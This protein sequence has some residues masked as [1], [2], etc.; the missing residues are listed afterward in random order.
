MDNPVRDITLHGDVAALH[1]SG[2]I[3]LRTAPSLRETILH[4]LGRDYRKL[5]VNL[6]DVSFM[7]S[8]GLSVLLGALRHLHT[9]GG[10]LLLAECSADIN[11]LLH[12][13]A[14]HDLLPAYSTES[15]AVAALHPTDLRPPA[16]AAP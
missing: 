11:D 15:E 5:V 9:C 12:L 6:R 16:P 10:D 3:D 8:I 7:D 4:L 2:H 14:G 1:I 13:T